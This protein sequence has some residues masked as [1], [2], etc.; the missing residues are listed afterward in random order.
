MEPFMI[1][2]YALPIDQIDEP[3]LREAPMNTADQRSCDQCTA[4]CFTHAVS[5]VKEGGEWCR[6]CDVGAGCR[7]YLSR[8]EQCRGFSCLWLQGRWGDEDDRPD[9]LKVVV[10]ELAVP[11]GNR[12]I[13]IVQFI[14]T[15]RGA[16]DQARVSALIGMY[17]TQGIAM[18]TARLEPSGSYGDAS[19]EIPISLLPENELDSFQQELGKLNPFPAR[20]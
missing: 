10:C 6:H 1:G 12:R 14:E 9:Y 5:T 2:K 3:A 4:C 18:C 16:L 20:K 17:R 19:Y 11:M 13:T 8:P 7:I 15:E